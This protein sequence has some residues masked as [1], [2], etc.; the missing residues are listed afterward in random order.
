[1]LREEADARKK[2]G[3]LLRAHELAQSATDLQSIWRQLFE[4]CVEY[5]DRAGESGP[6]GRE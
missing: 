2:A 6:A 3:D 5:A 1:L 4:M